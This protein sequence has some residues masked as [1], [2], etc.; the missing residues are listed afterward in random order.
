MSDLQ[1]TGDLFDT[2][3]ATRR[4]DPDSSKRAEH[5]VTSSGARKKHA[6]Q[7]LDLVRRFPGQTSK[8]LA[9]KAAMLGLAVADRHEMARRLADLKNKNLVRQEKPAEGDC[10]WWPL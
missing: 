10:R 9:K 4:S 2:P 6:E 5:R 8:E 3:P 7:A 1:M